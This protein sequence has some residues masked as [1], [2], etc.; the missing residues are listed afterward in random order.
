MVIFV[1]FDNSNFL[2]DM[3]FS[4]SWLK[5]LSGTKRSSEKLAELLLTHAF[6]VESVEVY[7]HGLDQVVIGKVL[8]VNQ[9]PNAD[10][11]RVA[12]VSVG[13]KDVREIVC[14][15]PN[16]AVGQKVA[17]ALPG[18]KLPGGIVI[19]ESE[20]RGIKSSGMMCS[21]K[22]L[23]FGTD[24][25]G[26]LVLSGDAPVGKDF[27]QYAGLD[28]TVMDIKI[29]PDRSCDALSYQGL[30]HE[31]A[32]LEGSEPAYVKLTSKGEYRLRKG[33][34][35]P[36]VT[37]KTERVGR[38][39]ALTLP[40]LILNPTPLVAQARLLLSG[41]RPISPVVDLTNYLMLET[42]QPIHAFDAAHIS[43]AGIVVRD[44]KKNEKLT[45]LDDT[46]LSLSKDDIVIAD[47]RHALA[48]AGVMGGKDS[49]ISETAAGVIFE[50]AHFDAQ[51]IRRTEKRYRLQTDAAY[52]FERGIDLGRPGEVMLL[53][54]Q[55]AVEWGLGQDF[56]YRDIGGKLPKPKVITLE[57]DAVASLLGF[58]VP[59]F[60]VVQ[61]CSWL[62]LS[63][64]K[65]PNRQ[66]LQ[67]T[68]PLRR[69]DLTTPE[70]I[71]EEIGR[72]RGYAV[73]DPKPLLLPMTPLLP[74]GSKA[75]ERKLKETLVHLGFDEVMTYS[76]YG[77]KSV[78]HAGYPIEEHLRLANPMNPDQALM[79]RSF[80]PR[81]LQAAL[82]NTDRFDRFSMFEFGSVYIP[83]KDKPTEEKRVG[84][85]M[86]DRESDSIEQSYRRFKGKVETLFEHLRVPM[87]FQPVLVAI[88]KHFQS[89]GVTH[90]SVQGEICGSM[91]I[92]RDGSLKKFGKRAVMLYAE[93]SL[94]G[95]MASEQREKVF[96]KIARFP[97]AERDISLVGPKEVMYDRLVE[98]IRT[99][100]APLLTTLELFDVYRTEEEKSFS[101]HLGFQSD[102][103]TL[104]SEEMDQAFDAIVAA[105]G[106]HLG[107]RLKL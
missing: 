62:G 68:V 46:V 107:M 75:F 70:D 88:P 78:M 32:A 106:E 96:Q 77:E 9:H 7:A 83:T 91:G 26:I 35:A 25:T 99:A 80:L 11:L 10:R 30:A 49:G 45:L 84:L 33:G 18:A 21:A 79:R 6:E 1:L 44:A 56:F 22:E 93:F 31:I 64:K 73:I 12:H 40:K 16:L 71:I 66:A 41:L 15:A 67:I 103:R 27:A 2:I 59:L 101:L 3:L 39:I 102:E 65:I 34:K 20:L 13:K 81:L 98:V 36:K 54:A 89:G 28:D 85:L 82:S 86:F 23:G 52:R 92:V 4:Y 55:R 17:V 94:G 53:L 38:Y 100:G 72:T 50:L 105:T 8:S 29:L 48:L 74:E 42:G 60:E 43:R 47:S 97:L 90:I 104:S 51:S 37:L 61:Y 57:L 5:E 58:K 95:M 69:P 63:V 76:F 14:G 24:H 87:N 19:K